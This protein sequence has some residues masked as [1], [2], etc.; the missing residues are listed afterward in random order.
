MRKLWR[1]LTDWLHDPTQARA[2]A[3]P[4]GMVI[5]LAIVFLSALLFPLFAYL[6]RWLHH[7]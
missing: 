2:S 1:W 5:M 3:V 4:C 6:M 7:R